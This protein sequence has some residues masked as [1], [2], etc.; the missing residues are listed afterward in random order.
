MSHYFFDSSALIK[1]YVAEQGSD[2]VRAIVAPSAGHTH[3]IAQITTVEIVSGAERLKREGKISQR[4]ARATRLMLD[5]H[6]SR[7]YTITSLTEKILTRAKDLLVHHQS[8]AYDA[9]Q[10]AS[11]LETNEHLLETDLPPLTFVSADERLL[12]A[13]AAEGLTTANLNLNS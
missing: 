8:R 2:W 9:V 7:E 12:N 10:L 1:R 13:A 3:I 5:R 6:A 4:T 11:A